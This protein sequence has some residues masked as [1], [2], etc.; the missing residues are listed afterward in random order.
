MAWQIQ[1]GRSDIMRDD[2]Q[3][4]RDVTNR[5]ATVFRLA[6]HGHGL[7]LRMIEK[8]TGIPY[9]TL[10]GY[11]SGAVAIP[12][13]NAVRLMTVLPDE[14]SSLLVEPAGKRVVSIDS[15]GEGWLD[16]LH[17]SCS[18]DAEIAEAESLGMTPSREAQ[19]RDHARTVIAKLQRVAAPEKTT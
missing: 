16:V 17:E 9:E 6:E 11:K 12:L 2:D 19:L 3:F 15:A 7:K 4:S 18:L 1:G 14:L 13:I 10:R 5:V 8:A